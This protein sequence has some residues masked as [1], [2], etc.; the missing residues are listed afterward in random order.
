VLPYE[1]SKFYHLYEFRVS[2]SLQILNVVTV[3]FLKLCLI[4][5]LIY[6]L[7]HIFYIIYFIN[8]RLKYNLYFYIFK[9]I[10]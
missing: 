1:P 7:N 5:H 6:F 10:F 4:I 3:D 9:L 2:Y 8:K